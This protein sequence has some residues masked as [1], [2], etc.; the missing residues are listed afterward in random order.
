MS[1][2]TLTEIQRKEWVTRDG[3]VIPYYVD[4]QYQQLMEG[5]VS[6]DKLTLGFPYDTALRGNLMPF[7]ILCLNKEYG[8]LDQEGYNGLGKLL[9]KSQALGRFFIGSISLDEHTRVYK[10]EH[11]PFLFLKEVEGKR[12]LFPTGY[13]VIGNASI[14]EGETTES[15]DISGT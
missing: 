9:S 15:S 13:Y 5:I 1:E 10:K 6:H 2:N 12:V 14:S 3:V 7:G 11:L 4:D 8:G